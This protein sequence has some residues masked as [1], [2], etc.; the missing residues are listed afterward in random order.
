MPRRQYLSEHS[1]RNTGASN[2][3]FN[4]GE[5]MNKKKEQGFNENMYVPVGRVKT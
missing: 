5:G 3:I 4:Y 1:P 2:P